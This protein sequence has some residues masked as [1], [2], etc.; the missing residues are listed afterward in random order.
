M[1]N[2][3]PGWLSSKYHMLR[4]GCRR[5]GI[6]IFIWNAESQPDVSVASH[7]SGKGQ[8]DLTDSDFPIPN[9]R[10]LQEMT[11]E[12]KAPSLHTKSK[13]WDSGVWICSFGSVIT[14]SAY[15]SREQGQLSTWET[16]LQYH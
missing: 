4:A 5:E 11:A 6:V 12:G 7:I 9:H 15:D 10:I 13:S 8:V 14:H 16:I 2:C 1:Y 3:V